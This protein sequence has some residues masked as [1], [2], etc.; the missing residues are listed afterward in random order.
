MVEEADPDKSSSPA[1][2]Q[3]HDATEEQQEQ[4]QHQTADLYKVIG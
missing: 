1:S 3:E 2:V 4:E